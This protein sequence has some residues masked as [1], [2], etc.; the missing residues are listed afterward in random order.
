MGRIFVSFHA[1][2]G[3]ALADR[4]V[5]ALEAAGYTDY[6]NYRVPGH[7]TAPGAAWAPDIRRNLLV[8]EAFIAITTPKALDEWCSTE[9]A[10]FRERK[11][12]APFLEIVVGEASRR[13]LTGALQGIRVRPDN[14]ESVAAA[15]ATVIA[16]LQA[17][18]VGTGPGRTSPYPGLAAF[19]E[20][21]AAVFFGRDDDIGRLA[22]AIEPRA[23]GAMAVVGPSGVGKSSL[24]LA[25]LVP[26][27]RGMPSS[28]ARTARWHVLGPVTPST[29]AVRGLA[30][31]LSIQ[32]AEVGLPP[33][34][35]ATLEARIRADRV[36]LAAML[37]EL[38]AAASARPPG[39]QIRVLIVLDQAE[40]LV[41]AASEPVRGRPEKRPDERWNESSGGRSDD[42]S[43]QQAEAV[44]LT[45]AL[46][47]A[48]YRNAW[49]VYTVRSDYLDDLLRGTTFRALMQQAHLVRPLDRRELLAVVSEPV[50]QLG[51]SYETD[52]LSAIVEDGARGSL[53]MLAYA[54]ARL[55]DRVN[56]GGDRE[57]RA[58]RRGE[59]DRA[60]RVQDV[61][62][63]QAEAA[64]AEALEQI[65]RAV[66][67]RSGA[68]VD[69]RAA[70]HR[71]LD[72]L[73]RLASVGPDRGFTRR[74]LMITEIGD[75]ELG[76][77]RPFVERRVLT[78]TRSLFVA[79]G[80]EQRA[81]ELAERVLGIADV[82]DN[83]LE[84]AHESLFGDWPRLRAHLGRQREALRA[85]GE[86]EEL[87]AAWLAGGKR[88]EDL[89]GQSRVQ[90]LLADLL[91]SRDVRGDQ[92]VT[93]WGW[94]NLADALVT[95]GIS[96]DA[97]QLAGLSIQRVLGRLVQEAV[98]LER[99]EDGLRLLVG[100]GTNSDPE[101]LAVQLSAP[102]LEGWRAAV[103]RAEAQ[104]RST[105]L[106]TD[107]SVG[108]SAGMWGVAWSPD[109]SRVATGSRDGVIRIWDL[110]AGDLVNAFAHGEDQIEQVDGWVRSVAWSPSAD[111]VAS[112]STDETTRVWS[113]DTGREVRSF[114]LPDRPWA[115]RFSPAGDQ[116]LTACASGHA[117]LWSTERRSR[118]PDYELLSK[119]SEA[120]TAEAGPTEGGQSDGGSRGG[121]PR[122][123]SDPERGIRIWDADIVT[124][125]VTRIATA[126]E[127]GVVDLWTLPSDRDAD[128]PAPRRIAAHPGVTVRSVRFSPGGGRIATAGQDNIIKVFEIEGGVEL[129][130]MSG[131][132]D[133][134]RRVAWS[135]L[136]NR[137]ASASA[138]TSIG[139]WDVHSGRR[140]LT[141]RGHRQGVC[142]VAWS[143]AGDQL[144]SVSDDGTARVWKIGAVETA[145][146][147]VGAPASAMDRSRVTGE[148]AVA[149]AA[150][151]TSATGNSFDVV[152]LRPD[153]TRTRTLSAA[154]RNTIRSVSWSP[155]GTRLLTASRDNTARIWRVDNVDYALENTLYAREGVEDARWSPDGVELVTAA[156]DRVVR[157]YRADGE[158]LDRDERRPHPN[159]L[160]AVA[161]HPSRPEFALAA[162][163]NRLTINTAEATVDEHRT[164]KVL[165]SV[166][167]SPTGEKLAL[168]AT[169]G[170]VLVLGAA[171]GR[172][173]GELHRLVGHEGEISTVDWSTDGERIVTS[174]A[175]HTASVWDSHTGAR[176]TSLVGHTGP[177]VGAVW[178]VDDAS[179]TNMV[180]TTASADGTIRTWDVSDIRRTPLSGLPDTEPGEPSAHATDQ[181][182]RDARVR[183]GR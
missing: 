126:C 112:A 176:L 168:G 92:T 25:G 31:A 21:D 84:V 171:D 110:S 2:E 175:D 17:R 172:I 132:T 170:T 93:A 99:P 24:V 67:G 114:R 158:W 26:R 72:L 46:V 160:R 129:R 151:P 61:L 8:S 90:F 97:V 127:D 144:I 100:A 89:I 44:V 156:R 59:Y 130:R 66:L 47:E 85:R 153:G 182:I 177:V 157:R 40:E 173:A 76:L 39:G 128:V 139:V 155:S 70:E 165:T 79:Q 19:G 54:L 18:G 1:A 174:S 140:V 77:L 181:L 123:R 62:R 167:W 142:D 78:T 145:L 45:E 5:R 133:Q 159:F 81:G 136:G 122:S 20:R 141:L 101:T 14:E 95:A 161:W 56:P 180:V 83:A 88:D 37:D 149:V 75:E 106:L 178:A 15:L 82:G 36:A 53:P 30:E 38:I 49:L 69:R 63:E 103:H 29:G 179:T 22:A 32:R 71:M 143:A 124:G 113:L 138:D 117:V 87:A 86:L 115:V 119:P 13:A 183:L 131:H 135:P 27:L 102:S 91:P 134:V 125:D 162:E 10:I 108:R 11:P 120:A 154:H 34:P 7:R 55:W 169:D 28:A 23:H 64:L 52:A 65:G 58:I 6:Y 137:V 148:I 152:V 3:G 80:T 147:L 166:A 109:G 98:L 96:A 16:F 50:H 51:W 41:L 163:D 107:R 73:S 116:V 35:A 9:V 43:V 74:P 111:L 33:V 48:S 94:P 42:L 121:G 105:R 60:G 146:V 118:R 68:T 4:V 164:D 12:R 150:G 104:L 57:P